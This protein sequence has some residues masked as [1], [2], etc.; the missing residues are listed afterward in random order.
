MTEDKNS[1][2]LEAVVT[3]DSKGQIVLPKELRVKA[4]I[5]DGD[6]L[7]V[8]SCKEEEHICCITLMKADRSKEIVRSMLDP[9]LDSLKGE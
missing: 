7:L 9:M 2:S 3:V 1:C 5:Q 8:I 4:G 6:K